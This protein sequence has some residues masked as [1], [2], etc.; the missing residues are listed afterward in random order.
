MANKSAVAA[1]GWSKRFAYTTSCSAMR[2]GMCYYTMHHD[3]I[4]SD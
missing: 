1:N 2:S 3:V 4:R